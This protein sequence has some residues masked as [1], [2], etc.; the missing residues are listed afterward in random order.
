MSAAARA[1]TATTGR[2]RAVEQVMGLPVSVVLRGRHAGDDVARAAWAMLV[3]ELRD[4]EDLFTTWR[5]D[6]PISRLGRGEIDLDDLPP[7]RAALVREVLA[8]GEQARRESD[9]AFDVR[10]RDASGALVLDPS[11]VVKGWALERVARHLHALPDTDSCL[12]GGGDLVC[13]AA[14]ADAEPWRIGVE[15]PADPARLLATVP[16]ARGAIAT[17]G[18]THRGA[19]VVDARTGRAPGAVASVTVVAVDLTTADVD[20]TAALA[21]DVEAADWLRSR[22]RTGLVVGVDGSVE[23]IGPPT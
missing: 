5:P 17:S 19:H 21:L 12:G 23:V 4:L 1:T 15:D 2:W 10:R 8:I 20:A 14:R 18:L 7:A 13:H 6:S 16:L 11:G 9:G 3:A 22:G